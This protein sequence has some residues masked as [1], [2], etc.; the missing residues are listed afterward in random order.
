MFDM[1]ADKIP[2]HILP[3]MSV[4]LNDLY[5]FIAVDSLARD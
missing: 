2:F 5:A 4:S 3:E 1:I